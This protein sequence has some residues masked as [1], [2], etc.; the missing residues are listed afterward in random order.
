MKVKLNQLVNSADSLRRIST[1]RVSGRL[2][3][4]IGRNMRLIDQEIVTYNEAR[5]K[6]LEQYGKLNDSKTQYIFDNGDAEKFNSDLVSLLQTEIEL[7]IHPLVPDDV[8]S[9]SCTS[10]D[11]MQIDWMIKDKSE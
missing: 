11:L 2:A 3:Y 4:R 1:E 9:F 8:D 6:L 5:I 7:D 10:A